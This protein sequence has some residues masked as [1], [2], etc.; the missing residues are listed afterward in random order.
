MEPVD[1]F[2]RLSLLNI[3][4]SFLK[5]PILHHSAVS[6]G[7]LCVLAAFSHLGYLAGTPELIST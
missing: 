3:L 4:L 1:F 6:Q 2:S 5:L 7:F